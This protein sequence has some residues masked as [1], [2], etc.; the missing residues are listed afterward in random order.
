[1]A[2]L[3]L[4]PCLLITLLAAALPPGILWQEEGWGYDAL[5]YHLAVPKTWFEQGRISVLPDNVY[6]AM[7]F[8]GPMLWLLMMVLHGDAIDAVFMAQMVNVALGVLFV[9]AAWKLGSVYGR[10][11]A[12]VAAV[13][14]G[15]CPWVTYLCG[16]AYDEAGML[17]MGMAALWA[18]LK[19]GQAGGVSEVPIAHRSEAGVASMRSE[20]MASNPVEHQRGRWVIAA[21]LLAGLACGYKYTAL[22]LIALPIGLLLVINLA[23]GWRR[24]AMQMAV[25]L[26]A[27]LALLSPWLIRNQIA[28]G[29]PIFPL[30]YSVFGAG[31]GW[32]DYELQDRWREA[33]GSALSELSIRQWIWQ[34]GSRTLAEPRIGA[35]LWALAVGGIFLRRDRLTLALIALLAM[36]LAVW[37]LG[38]H[39]FAR[40][41]CVVIL[42]LVALAARLPTRPMARR[43]AGLFAG[44]VVLGAVLNICHTAPLYYHHTRIGERQL[45]INAYGQ[46][47]WFKEGSWPG[48]QWIGMINDSLQG[49]VKVMLVGEARTFYLKKSHQSASAFNHHPLASAARQYTDDTD[50]LRWLMDRGVTHLLFHWEEISRLQ[51]TYGLDGAINEGLLPRLEMG[52]VKQVASFRA[53]E[54]SPVYATLYEVPRP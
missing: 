49:Q 35:L 19:A 29:N 4:A 18:A 26:L 14:A 38:T 43:T 3:L 32:W 37:S 20:E 12:V 6:S 15:T 11:S 13:A 41:A 22:P 34:A 50:L 33:H 48:T 31:P 40:F 39:L 53:A 51:T 21:G 45:L 5:S 24:R 44:V 10:V 54:D 7:P 8:N 23:G 25:Y 47:A 17:A 2:L 46:T 52:G 28:T 30:G 9:L 16:I 36:Q 27:C 1:M 42:P